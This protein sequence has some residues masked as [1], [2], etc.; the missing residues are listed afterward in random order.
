MRWRAGARSVV[1]SIGVLPSQTHTSI[2]V[3][4]PFESSL[5]WDWGF[6][7]GDGL[8]DGTARHFLFLF[9]QRQGVMM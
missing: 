8:E 4:A 9:T 1:V 6:P 2:V 5:A 7:I 3:A